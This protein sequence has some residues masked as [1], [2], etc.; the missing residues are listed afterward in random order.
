M[1]A[2]RRVQRLWLAI[3]KTLDSIQFKTKDFDANTRKTAAD[4]STQLKDK[5]FVIILH[6]VIDILEN[7]NR[8]SL[9]FQKRN[10]LLI[11]KHQTIQ[12]LIDSVEKLIENSGPIVLTYL[13]KATC[14]GL[15]ICN[16]LN[17]DSS[18]VNYL[19]V[20]LILSHKINTLS[21]FRRQL[22]YNLLN[23]IKS[24]FPDNIIN[25]FDI[26]IPSNLPKTPEDT[27]YYGQKEISLISDFFKLNT[28]LIRNEFPIFLKKILSDF[29]LWCEISDQESHIFYAR[30]LKVD[31]LPLSIKNLI[32]VL[33]VLPIGIFFASIL[34][35]F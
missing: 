30:A 20:D 25:A 32:K 17:Y 35:M 29:D 27:I 9:E 14:N 16:L 22:T 2:V 26:F 4:L 10:G 21:L 1:N 12:N 15:H 11:G 31:G 7:L 5:N 18:T 3:I 28:P 24:Y 13:Q 33:L 23:Q 6:F 19:G 8:Y 34:L